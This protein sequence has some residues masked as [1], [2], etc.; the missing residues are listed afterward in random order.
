MS[1]LSPDMRPLS[2]CAWL[3]TGVLFLT[4]VSDGLCKTMVTPSVKARGTYDDSVLGKGESDLEILLSPAL[5]VVMEG[6]VASLSFTGRLDAFR[7]AEHS[8]YNRENGHA[9]AELGYSLSER[10]RLRMG[11]SWMRDHTVET[12]YAESGFVTE[13]VPRNLY[14][15]TPGLTVLVSER[16]ELAV[17]ISAQSVDYERAAY[18]DYRTLGSTATWSHALRNELWRV[19]GQASAYLYRFDHPGGKTDQLVLTGLV[20]LSWRAAEMLEFQM[21]GGISQTMSSVNLDWGEDMEAKQLTFSGSLSATWTDEVWKL[22][23]AA[24]RSESPSSYGELITRDR[25][26]AVFGRNLSERLYCGMQAA[27]YQSKTRGLVQDKDTKTY[28]LGP[29]A[30]YRL[31]EDVAVEGGYQFIREENRAS[32][33]T[34]DRNKVYLNLS[35]D[36]PAEW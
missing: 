14:S 9:G 15:V 26:R 19:M 17:D 4:A 6:E 1:F 11:V 29:V 12:E 3:C 36:F 18:T 25:L 24:D 34:T 16:D 28:L 33:K 23:V 7:Y 5:Q 32:D 35:M 27:W 2:F 20:G 10:T 8:E 30:R 13:S 22:H 21:M 31:S